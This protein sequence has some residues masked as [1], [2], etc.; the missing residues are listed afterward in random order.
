MQKKKGKIMLAL[1]LYVDKGENRFTWS[2]LVL[3]SFNLSV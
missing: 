1:E 3:V 2:L